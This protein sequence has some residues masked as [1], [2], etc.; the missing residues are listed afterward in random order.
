MRKSYFSKWM[1]YG[2]LAF[3]VTGFVGCSEDYDDEIAGLETRIDGLEQSLKQLEGKIK[4]GAVITKVT[5]TENGLSVTLSDGSSYELKNG[6]NGKD[7]VDGTNGVDGTPGS[8]ISIDS[9][10]GN[11]LIDGNDTGMPSRGAQGIQGEKG[12]KGDQ[13][14]QGIQGEK[15]DKGDQGAQGIQGEKGDKGDQGAQGIQGEKGDKGD[16][17]AQGIQGEKGDKGDQGEQGI[18]GEKGDKGD[19]GE[20][21]IQGEKGDKGDKGDTGERGPKGEDGTSGAGLKGDQ[22]VQGKSVY[23]YPVTDEKSENYGKWMKVTEDP[24]N[25]DNPKFEEVAEGPDGAPLSWL[26]AVPETIVAVWDTDNNKLTLNGITD[27]DG[28]LLESGYTFDLASTLTSIAFVPEVISEKL[29]MGIIDFYSLMKWEKETDWYQ[30]AS[31]TPVA[32]YRMNPANANLEGIEWSFIDRTV[33]SRAAGDGSTLLSIEKQETSAGFQDFSLKLNK[34]LPS[35]KNYIVALRATAANG[36]IIVSDY[37]N[38]Q[39]T[40]LKNFSI[41]RE[42]LY[43]NDETQEFLNSTLK[44]VQDADPTIAFVYT[45]ELDLAECTE[46]W[47]NELPN[48]VRTLEGIAPTYKFEKISEYKVGDENTDQQVFVTLDENGVVKVAEKWGS[49]AIDKTPIFKVTAYVNNIELASGY[50]KV[51]IAAKEPI[52]QTTYKK[53]F[54]ATFDYNDLTKNMD[55][56][57]ET[58]QGILRDL[59][60]NTTDFLSIYTTNSIVKEKGVEVVVTPAAGGVNSDVIGVTIDNTVAAEFDKTTTGKAVVTYKSNDETQYPNIEI[61][62]TY[63]INHKHAALEYN[64]LF[65]VVENGYDYVIADGMLEGGVLVMKTPFENHFAKTAFDAIKNNHGEVK[66]RHNPDSKYDVEK[67]LYTIDDNGETISLNSSLKNGEVRDIHVQAYVTAA[68]GELCV[69]NNY[70]VRFIS[71]FNVTIKPIEMK[72]DGFN[73]V[74]VD[75]NKQL[76]IK[77]RGGKV[78][79]ENGEFA[80]DLSGYDF[81]KNEGYI[82]KTFKLSLKETDNAFGKLKV[83]ENN[84]IQWSSSEA[85]QNPVNT[86]LKLTVDFGTYATVESEGTVTVK[87]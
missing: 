38:V 62:F 39:S 13:G 37:A 74:E 1:L 29:G 85:L 10:S 14:A 48:Y 34:K 4:E 77:T 78:L 26:P 69:L 65:H 36:N 19:Q 2:A 15:G 8:V 24:A 86:T 43:D 42:D 17:G 41:I 25:A 40:Q 22:G 67:D 51:K 5:P 6:A 30:V 53:E 76:V 7:G 82:T 66:F 57:W 27:K 33:T 35:D 83:V 61:T 59:E 70:A 18:Q 56:N 72:H 68:N 50:I 11:W 20:Q 79:Y 16:Q 23:Y 47:A 52:K 55:M 54:K 60:I 28:N 31:N 46:L 87:P 49:T 9:E 21:G 44:T 3:S 12:D 73:V 63:T 58:F 32:S 45:G 75:L 64:D 81:I 84:K 80:K 71:Q